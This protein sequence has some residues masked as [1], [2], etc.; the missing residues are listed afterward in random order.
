MDVALDDAVTSAGGKR[1]QSSSSSNQWLNGNGSVTL[2]FSSLGDQRKN[3]EIARNHIGARALAIFFAKVVWS[4]HCNLR[5]H[6]LEI[7]ENIA[8]NYRANGMPGCL[9]SSYVLV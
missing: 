9:I 5:F 8:Y 3:G 4:G 2:L 1:A 7:E 6:D